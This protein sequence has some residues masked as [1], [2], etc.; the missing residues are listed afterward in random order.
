MRIYVQRNYVGSQEYIGW[1][2]KEHLKECE[3]SWDGYSTPEYWYRTDENEKWR[4]SNICPSLIED[5]E[6]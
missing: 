4:G 6:S 1:T 5:Y 3:K 2:T